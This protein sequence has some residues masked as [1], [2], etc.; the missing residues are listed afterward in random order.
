MEANDNEVV[1]Y[2]FRRPNRKYKRSC[3]LEGPTIGSKQLIDPENDQCCIKF[4]RS[5]DAIWINEDLPLGAIYGI[6]LMTRND[7]CGGPESFPEVIIDYKASSAGVK[8]VFN[9][10][11]TTVHLKTKLNSNQMQF[12]RIV[13]KVGLCDR[14]ELDVHIMDV[15]DHPPIF[16]RPNSSQNY[17]TLN[18]DHCKINGSPIYDIEIKDEDR[19]CGN[20]QL[21]IRGK[22]SHFFKIENN[23]L[24]CSSRTQIITLER[25]YLSIFAFDGTFLTKTY[26]NINVTRVSN[27]IYCF[28]QEPIRRLFSVSGNLPMALF[29]IT[30]YYYSFSPQNIS[31][32][33]SL[34]AN[35]LHNDALY[36]DG[37]LLRTIWLLQIPTVASMS[38][39]VFVDGGCKLQFIVEFTHKNRYEPRISL[40]MFD[41][42]EF[43]RLRKDEEYSIGQVIAMD[44]DDYNPGTRNSLLSY[45]LYSNSSYLMLDRNTGTIIVKDPG[46]EMFQLNVSIAVCDHGLDEK[47]VRT[48]FPIT[49][50]FLDI[51][52]VFK[53]N[54]SIEVE[55]DAE[56]GRMI[57]TI[58]S[59]F[60]QYLLKNEMKL[61]VHFDD[62]HFIY[63]NY[64]IFVN[65]KLD[66]E[67][68]SNHS[69]L[70]LC[71]H[72]TVCKQ[73]TIIV[74]DVNDNFPIFSNLSA[75]KCDCTAQ[76]RLE[77]K[78]E[79]YDVDI[80]LNGDI[81]Y[82]IEDGYKSIEVDPSNGTIKC[83]PSKYTNN[84]IV[85]YNANISACDQGF[86]PKCSY[87]SVQLKVFKEQIICNQQETVRLEKINITI[88]IFTV[89]LKRNVPLHV[90]AT[91]PS[92]IS[93]HIEL[94]NRS[95]YLS[96]WFCCVPQFE[97]YLAAMRKNANDTEEAVIKFVVHPYAF[98]KA[99][100]FNTQI[101][102][103]QSVSTL[104]NRDTQFV[105]YAVSLP[106]FLECSLS[107]SQLIPHPDFSVQPL[108]GIIRFRY[109]KTS[110]RS[111]QSGLIVAAHP[112]CDGF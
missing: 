20:V 59:E 13:L 108:T 111:I 49:V 52:Q 53:D 81:I 66:R 45:E 94:H 41:Q 70:T 16:I 29:N 22:G 67:V 34:A 80:G 103:Y 72:S 69:P 33:I 9:L 93:D 105:G 10:T 58:P 23:Q 110:P 79:A 77:C 46:S 42:N 68:Q 3:F 107:F 47:C 74:V 27:Q 57:W 101:D 92:Y 28:N 51:N 2:T 44:D 88:P 82:G 106:P 56:V 48:S 99:I 18:F 25:C 64:S 97:V 7:C 61:D 24:V 76:N 62:T 14:M 98:Q 87:T 4:G 89:C 71:V 39:E 112:I 50:R 43:L 35:E 1:C 30:E 83:L 91:N 75:N 26:L 15:N 63:S 104:R 100:R 17:L 37:S 73:I 40:Q 36:I 60:K 11:D 78:I 95:I 55:E 65:K 86:S 5:T 84:Q 19:L 12:Y 109:S 31:L 102:V 21:F 85:T 96:K 54:Q 6:S 32:E 8:N 90:L 38:I